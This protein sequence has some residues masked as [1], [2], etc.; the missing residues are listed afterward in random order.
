MT[1]TVRATP[2]A[3][4]HG[5][6]MSDQLGGLINSEHTHNPGRDQE[7]RFHGAYTCV[8]EGHDHGIIDAADTEHG[9]PS[10]PIGG[11]NAD[12]P[13]TSAEPEPDDEHVAPP[14]EAE[15]TLR[16]MIAELVRSQKAS[17]VMS[18]A[19]HRRQHPESELQRA[20]VRHLEVRAVPGLVWFHVPQGNKL[21][22]KI[23][24][25]GIA[26]QGAINKALGVK[27]GVSDLILLHAGKFYGLELK[28]EGRTP[29]AEQ[30]KFIDDVNAAGG[31]AC[32]CA[33]IDTALACLSA[34]GLLRGRSQ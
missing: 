21:G 8:A 12:E 7:L 25:K 11:E 5:P 24:A 28:A 33:G 34:W 1:K 3:T 26:V 31:F 14:A 23:S 10:P 17:A 16:G 4:G 18:S 32:W 19:R 13:E 29:T 27:R 2:V 22:G 9:A 20:L 15:K 6:R 30:L